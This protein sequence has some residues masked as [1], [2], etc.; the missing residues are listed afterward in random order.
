MILCKLTFRN[1][2]LPIDVTSLGIVI[3]VKSTHP[4]NAL[5]PTEPTVSGIN[6]LSFNEAQPLNISSFIASML[7]K[8]ISASKVQPLNI[9]IPALVFLNTAFVS[10]KLFSNTDVPTVPTCD[11]ITISLKPEALNAL[12]PIVK[13]VSGKIIL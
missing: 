13:T 7:P 3:S 9:A 1:T 12:S 2:L 5:V 6:G 8:L 10:D 11:G 4:A